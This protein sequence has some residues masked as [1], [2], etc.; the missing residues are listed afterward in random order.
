[1]KQEEKMMEKEMENEEAI[2]YGRDGDWLLEE[3]DE[4]LDAGTDS[5]GEEVFSCMLDDLLYFSE[6]IGLQ[7]RLFHLLQLRGGRLPQEIRDLAE[8]IP[9][10]ATA[11]LE[12]WSLYTDTLI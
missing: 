3:L 1:M 11:V 9:E 12:K 4:L 10:L 2:D 8:D 5:D 7:A 6:L